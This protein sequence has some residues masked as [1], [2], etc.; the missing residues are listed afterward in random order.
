MEGVRGKQ[1]DHNL[2]KQ[3]IVHCCSTKGGKGTCTCN[4]N[5]IITNYIVH[6]SGAGLSIWF[7]LYVLCVWV[8]VIKKT[9]VFLSYQS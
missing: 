3:I 2:C 1:C 5:A 7:R 9:Y 8:Y 6:V 4:S